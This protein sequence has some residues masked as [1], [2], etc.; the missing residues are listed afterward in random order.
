[1]RPM[2]CGILAGSPAPTAIRARIPSGFSERGGCEMAAFQT[3]KN[4]G[5][6]RPPFCVFLSRRA[7]G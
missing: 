7:L 6:K 4:E 5:G 1:M 2:L 3:L